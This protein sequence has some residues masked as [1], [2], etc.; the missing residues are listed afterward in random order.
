MNSKIVMAFFFILALIACSNK[1][2]EN[3]NSKLAIQN[4][5]KTLTNIA[6][7]T[8]KFIVLVDSVHD[9]EEAIDDDYSWFINIQFDKDYFHHLKKTIHSSANYNTIQYEYDEKWKDIDTTKGKGVWYSDS[10]KL[11]FIQ[12]P[13]EFNSEPIILSVDT[14]T[15]KLNLLIIHL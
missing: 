9:T 10:N 12:N 2:E 5:I 7:D 14:L 13:K 8:S 4:E 1:N 3:Y 15:Q 6:L 11:D